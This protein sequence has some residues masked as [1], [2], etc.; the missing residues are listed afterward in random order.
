[1]GRSSPSSYIEVP[2]PDLQPI[3][4]KSESWGVGEI[5]GLELKPGFA[6]E[7]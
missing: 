5:F 2:P 1:M 6:N 7:D 4:I 3:K